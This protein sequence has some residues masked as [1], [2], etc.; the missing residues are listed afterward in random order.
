VK[1][2]THGPRRVSM[3]SSEAQG[4]CRAQ[5]SLEDPAAVATYARKFATFIVLDADGCTRARISEEST[6][7]GYV[8][9][10]YN[11]RDYVPFTLS[12]APQPGRP[13][14]VRGAYRSS[15]SQ[16]IKFSVSTPL[17][18]GAHWAGTISGSIIAAST[19]DL[20]RMKRNET[21]NQM[22]VLLGPFDG[23]RVA[24]RKLCAL[25]EFTFLVHPRLPRGDKVTIEPALS[26]ELARVFRPSAEAPQFELATALPLQ[27][28]DYID[29][30]LKQRWLAAFAPVG[31]TG[32]VVLVQTRDA[33]AIRPSNGLSRIAI[34]LAGGSAAL[35]LTYAGFL[36][37]RRKRERSGSSPALA[38]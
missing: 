14:H 38:S 5:T 11:W 2:L 16:L 20:P 8:R 21:T 4:P 30:L 34:T 36:L 6:F 31:G 24:T 7:P 29:P 37:W 28:A 9:N 32:Y 1:I 15:I 13:P 3:L 35:L 17:F 19:L 33:V 18:E 26:A 23:V 25:P 22:T 27:R 12:D 10:S